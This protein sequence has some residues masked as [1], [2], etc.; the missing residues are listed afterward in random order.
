[1]KSEMTLPTLKAPIV[2]VHGLLGYDQ[3][4]IGKWLVAD[5]WPGILALYRDAGNRVL[6]VRLSPTDGVATRAGQLRA[7]IRAAFPGE[8]VH[9]IAHSMGGLDSRYMISRLD[10]AERVLSL[11]TIATP[12]R[13]SPFAD[14]GIRH[15]Q[16]FVRP[17]LIFSGIS[18]EAFYDLCTDRC[19]QLAIEAPDVPSVRYFSVAGA[20]PAEE[21]GVQWRAFHD[22]VHAAE[23]EN[24]GLVS[25]ASAR[26]GE[27]LDRWEGDHLGLVNWPHNWLRTRRPP[28][29]R[30][31]HYAELLRRL[32]DVG[33]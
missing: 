23:G 24:D 32:A 2:L 28:P 20:L 9:L 29:D 14:W 25:V 18:H 33:F 19:K 5:Y 15:L 30:L 3:I 21:F 17:F 13:G 7:A 26:Y 6:T 27:V 4:K 1:M 12:H 10:M 11:T 22:I 8:A 31:P 16:G